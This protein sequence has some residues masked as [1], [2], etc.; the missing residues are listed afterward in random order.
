MAT[1]VK[2]LAAPMQDVLLGDQRQT[3]VMVFARQH[4]GFTR[5]QCKAITHGQAALSVGL[6]R[7][8]MEILWASLLRGSVDP[9]PRRS[10]GLMGSAK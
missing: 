9:S 10:P 4:G 5:M 8:N 1:L 6:R 2:D 3:Q 7:Q